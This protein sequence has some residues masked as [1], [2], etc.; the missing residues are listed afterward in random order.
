MM[1]IFWSKTSIFCLEGKKE[2]SSMPLKALY[3][4]SPAL[5]DPIS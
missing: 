2:I 5:L 4:L 1:S 3:N